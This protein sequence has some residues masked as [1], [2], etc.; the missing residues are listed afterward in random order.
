MTQLSEWLKTTSNHRSG[1]RDA[2]FTGIGSRQDSCR[3]KN[4]APMKVRSPRGA[5]QTVTGEFADNVA[6]PPTRT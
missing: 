4:S 1:M 6:R 5:V 3:A 2:D